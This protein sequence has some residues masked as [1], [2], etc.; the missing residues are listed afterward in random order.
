MGNRLTTRQAAQLLGIGTSTVY[1]YRRDYPDF[2]KPERFGWALSWDAGEL[3][4][5]REEHPALRAGG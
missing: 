1:A 3:R 4:R 2:P 5:W